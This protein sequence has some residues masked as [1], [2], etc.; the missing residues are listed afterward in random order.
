[1]PFSMNSTRFYMNSYIK[2]KIDGTF[3]KMFQ[4]KDFADFQE[5]QR[6]EQ[7]IG[8]LPKNQ[9]LKTVVE[10]LTNTELST[11]IGQINCDYVSS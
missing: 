6:R 5:Q 8:V 10:K 7:K 3:E 4:R 11:S 1:M 9:L 2:H